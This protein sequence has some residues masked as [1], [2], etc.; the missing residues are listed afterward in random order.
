MRCGKLEPS[1]WYVAPVDVQPAAVAVWM[2]RW[3]GVDG[4]AK[5]E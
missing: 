2:K 1:Q 4:P 3:F 5:L